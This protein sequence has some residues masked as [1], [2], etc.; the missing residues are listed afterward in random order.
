M[1][2]AWAFVLAARDHLLLPSALRGDAL[3]NL[4]GKNFRGAV[5]GNRVR[6]SPAAWERCLVQ[7]TGPPSPG[8]SFYLVLGLGSPSRG[9]A[10]AKASGALD[11]AQM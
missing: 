9:S 11:L 2:A 6:R 3:I 10:P 4:R 1:R 5:A 8:G 7:D